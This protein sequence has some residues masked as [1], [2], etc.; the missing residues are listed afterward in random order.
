MSTKQPLAKITSFT[1]MRGK[2]FVT[3]LEEGMKLTRG[4]IILTDDNMKEHGIRPRWAK[5]W[6]VGPDVDDVTPGEWVLVEH[7]RWT[8]RIP[9]DIEGEGKI[10]VWMIEPSAIIIVSDEAEAPTETVRYTL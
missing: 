7:G 6:R 5:V 2:I 3:D 8:L 9:M 4:G 1:P 10:D